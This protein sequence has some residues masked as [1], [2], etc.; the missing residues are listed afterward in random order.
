MRGIKKK[1][2]K[3]N[4]ELI[5][6]FINLK[7]NAENYEVWVPYSYHGILGFI[8]LI[9]EKGSE[10]S[11][12][13]FA[14]DAKNI[15]KIVK[16]FKLEITVYPKTRETSS[17]NI[18]SYLVFEDSKQNRRKVLSEKKLLEKQ[19]FEIMF[20]NEEK[21]RI[22]SIFKLRDS[23]PRLFQTRK[24]RLNEE[25]LQELITN[26]NHN[27]IE[28]AILNLEDPPETITR[29]LVRE[30]ER[31]IER[32]DEF[33]SNTETLKKEI[34]NARTQSYQGRTREGDMKKAKQS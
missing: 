3:G 2:E 4:S 24:I 15:E 9:I 26:P 20:L 31:Y 32:K 16:N 27:Q 14:R 10:I 17:K 22:E 19:P 21:N 33:P 29:E 6:S 13:K 12:F 30:T 18:G 34:G 28:R 1:I 5:R 7:D 23:L 8:D 25:A 11:I